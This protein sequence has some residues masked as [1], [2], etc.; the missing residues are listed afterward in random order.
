MSVFLFS[1]QFFNLWEYTFGNLNSNK[2]KKAC[3]QTKTSNKMNNSN[4]WYDIR[5]KI[6]EMKILNVHKTDIYQVL[7]FV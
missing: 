2:T 6:S 7:N 5:G 1:A 4:K 3:K